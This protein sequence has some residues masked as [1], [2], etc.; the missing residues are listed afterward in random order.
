M[1]NIIASLLIFYITFCF[2]QKIDYNNF[3]NYRASKVLFEELNK[4]RDTITITGYGKPLIEVYPELKT[5]PELKKFYW[6]EKIYTLISQPNCLENVNQNRLFHVD[7][8][9]WWENEDNRKKFRNEIYVKPE[10]D[11]PNYFIYEENGGRTNT[12]FETYQEMA[13]YMI[14]SWEKSYTHRCTQRAGLYSAR[15]FNKKIPFKT[16]A[17]CSVQFSN[18]ETWF[19]TNIIHLP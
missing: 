4:F 13:K 9:K 10:K 2:S 14:N 5:N 1:K 15:S 8:S 12:K 18:G 19:F 3:D 17:A 6:S 11:D 16:I 7:R